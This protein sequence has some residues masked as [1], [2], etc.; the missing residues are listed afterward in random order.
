MYIPSPKELAFLVIAKRKQL[1]LTQTQVADLVG[2]KQKSISAFE[3]KPENTRLETLFRI[4]AALNLD[5]KVTEKEAATK[6]KKVW[7]QEW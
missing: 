1:G 2:L 7:K 3:N 4:L 6:N 5:I